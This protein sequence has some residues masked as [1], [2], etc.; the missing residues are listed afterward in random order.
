MSAF[1]KIFSCFFGKSAAE[2]FSYERAPEP[3][4]VYW[5][6]V[7]VTS[8]QRIIRVCGTYVATLALIGI[9]FGIIYGLN[10]A[11]YNLK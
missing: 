4:D 3:T 6:N 7:S 1:K 10:I 5:E 11:K 9:C 2:N 8:V